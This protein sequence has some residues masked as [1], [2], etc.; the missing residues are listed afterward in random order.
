MNRVLRTIVICWMA[1]LAA[2]AQPLYVG[3]YNIRYQNND[4]KKNGNG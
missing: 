2:G 1:V 3:S 4:D